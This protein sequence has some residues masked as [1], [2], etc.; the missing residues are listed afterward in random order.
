MIELTPVYSAGAHRPTFLFIPG[1]F[2][3]PL[4][5]GRPID[6]SWDRQTSNFCRSYDLNGAIVRW[7]SGNILDL[8]G[9][10]SLT[11]A[12]LGSWSSTSDT[13]EHAAQQ[14]AQYIER[15]ETPVIVAG[16]SLGGKIALLTAQNL[17]SRQLRGLVALAPACD[18]A[19]INYRQVAEHVAHKPAVCFSRRDKVLSTL[20][21]CGQTSH[22]VMSALKSSFKS[23]KHTLKHLSQIVDQRACSPALGLVGVPTEYRALYESIDTGYRHL[24]YCKNLNKTLSTLRF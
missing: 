8:L 6:N 10:P 16:H 7:P 5:Q 22:A 3:Q 14:L 24:E 19:S 20:F 12:A 2:T 17:E 11:Q 21:A 13:A 18:V 23:P 4:I 15:L 9:S 1:Y